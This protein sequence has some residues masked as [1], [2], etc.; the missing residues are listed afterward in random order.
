MKSSLPS[1]RELQESYV[2]VAGRKDSVFAMQAAR[3]YDMPGCAASLRGLMYVI[4]SGIVH[5]T[6]AECSSTSN[7]ACISSTYGFPWWYIPRPVMELLLSMRPPDGLHMAPGSMKFPSM[8]F[9]LPRNMLKGDEDEDIAYLNV[10]LLNDQVIAEASAHHRIEI[11][12]N[13]KDQMLQVSAWSGDGVM[14]HNT[15]P[16]NG[17]EISWEEVEKLPFAND[18]S[19][20]CKDRWGTVVL[21][22]LVANLLTLM[23]VKPEIVE[24][25][26]PLA[27]RVKKT[28]TDIWRPRLVGRNMK[29]FV[30]TA[31]GEHE[32]GGGWTVRPHMRGAHW[33]R[34]WYGEGKKLWKQTLIA[35]TPVN[36][37]ILESGS[38]SA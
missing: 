29:R 37:G 26:S 36:W 28:G 17:D 21:L 3:S 9:V 15:V 33:K 19:Q 11:R 32:N 1:Q 20:T 30:R 38:K 7:A 35:E 14:F 23:A 8:W 10:T 25:T 31:E 27:R 34:V 22:P 16:F 4:A 13:S 24:S 12:R 6:E 2:K 5:S 18:R